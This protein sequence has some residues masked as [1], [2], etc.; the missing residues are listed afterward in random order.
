MLVRSTCRFALKEWAAVC[1]RLARGEIVLL[2]RKGGILERREGFQA[3]HREFFLFPTRFHAEGAPPPGAV[4]LELFAE[5]VD[6][7]HVRDLDA[8]RR[9]EGMHALGWEDVEKRFHYGKAPGLHALTLRAWRLASPR[10]VENARDYDGCVSWVELDRELEVERG[11][12]AL[13][14]VEFEARRDAARAALRSEVE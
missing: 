6:D 12:P 7:V 10:R 9:L 3:E 2:L 1:A 5:V 13:D 14:D 8:L 4:D 11:A